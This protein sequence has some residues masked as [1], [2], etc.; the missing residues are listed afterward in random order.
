MTI[1][2]VDC[3][4][5][6]A[7]L[8]VMPSRWTQTTIESTCVGVMPDTP[9]HSATSRKLPKRGI[10]RESAAKM[11]IWRDATITP[12]LCRGF[13]AMMR[14]GNCTQISHTCLQEG[15][16]GTLSMVIRYIVFTKQESRL[17]YRTLPCLKILD[18]IS[19]SKHI[20]VLQ[21]YLFSWIKNNSHFVSKGKNSFAKNLRQ[22][23]ILNLCE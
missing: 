21:I 18:F 5:T 10:V 8:C 13:S 7:G 12:P 16:A 6:N 20:T 2:S 9:V 15:E 11:W 22:K 23:A 17:E 3:R 14:T 1:I 4:K 19:T